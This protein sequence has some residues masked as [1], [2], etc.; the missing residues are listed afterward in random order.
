MIW[1]WQQPDWP[2]FT[3]SAHRLNQAEQRFLVGGGVLVGIVEHVGVEERD[4]LIVEAMGTEA[5]TT[6][7]IEGEVLDRE[8]VQSSI[9]QQLGFGSDHRRVGAAERGISEL[10][11]DLYKRYDEPLT[12]AR[13]LDWHRMVVGDRND[14]QDIGRYR[15]HGEPMQVVS[16]R[17]DRSI[18]HFEAP[19][20]ERVAAEMSRFLEWFDRT[21][22]GG[23]APLPA[24]TR[25][26][27]A[28]LYFESI[29]PFEDGNGR[30]G[31][32]ISELAL[33]QSL[34]RPSLVALA[35]MILVRRREYYE[36]LG[37]ANRSMEAS[38]W[39]AWFA[40]IALEAQQRRAAQIQFL[41]AK[42]RLI[43]RFRDRMNERQLAAV[44]RMAREGPAGFKGGLSAGKYVAITKSSTATATRDLAE[45]AEMGVVV[46][47]GERRG[48]RY[49]LAISLPSLP[50]IT[51]APDGQVIETPTS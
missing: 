38:A 13:L 7:E 18:V 36:A 24:L 47:T 19:P 49:H 35:A 44:L 34:G 50:R 45:I 25:S 23:P 1:N 28:H 27:I 16:G 9:R 2:E 10:M 6:S 14:L 22:P 41:I 12:E 21:R 15:T 8:S 26:G 17:M 33:A 46:R 39:A 31:R 51:I 40:G 3:W 29:H 42:T 5:V 20:R 48:T 4:Q 37:A 11:V 43:D 30:L 32:A